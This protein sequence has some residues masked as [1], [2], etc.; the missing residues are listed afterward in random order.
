RAGDAIDRVAVGERW[1]AALKKAV[2]RLFDDELVGSSPIERQN[3]A[4]IARAHRQLLGNLQGPKLRNALGLPVVTKPAKK[5]RS[6]SSKK[7]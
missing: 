6:D 1:L 7:D 2:H 3:P 5:T 4:R